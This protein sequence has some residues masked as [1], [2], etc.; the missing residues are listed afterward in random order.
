M[1]KAL[2]DWDNITIVPAIL[3]DISSR[4]EVDI[5]RDGKLPLFVSPMDTV[6][7]SEN[8]QMYKDLG[9]E[10]CLPRGENDNSED[11]FISYGLSEIIDLIDSK[12]KLPKRVLIDIANAHMRLLYDTS[13]RLKE[14]YPGTELMIGNIANPETY[15]LYAE[16]GVDYIRC[17]IGGGSACTTSAN[18]S[19]HYPMGSLIS[20]IY[21]IKKNGKYKTKIVADGGFKKFSDII[22]ALAVGADMIMLGGVLNKGLESTSPCFIAMSNGSYKELALED[23]LETTLPIYKYFRGMSTK[24]VQKKWGSSKLKTAEGIAFYSLVEYTIPQWTENFE[25]YL[26]SALSYSNVK[27]IDDFPTNV[28]CRMVT[29]E[30]FLRFNK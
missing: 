17:G 2:Y 14:L 22:K 15:K 3:S 13:K 28:D 21:E 7:D 6:V 16:L 26:R 20:E 9:F 27:N 10:V 25:A 8:S 23:A 12:S 11:S 5:F 29:R 24:E 4:S 30:A 1:K 18:S 19:V